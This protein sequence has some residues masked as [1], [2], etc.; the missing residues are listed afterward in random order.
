MGIFFCFQCAGRFRGLGTHIAFVRSV[1][2]DSWTA[3][4]IKAMLLS[5]GNDCFRLFMLERANV[6]LRDTNSSMTFREKYDNNAAELYRRIVQARVREEPEPTELLPT[7]VESSSTGPRRMEGFGSSPSPNADG[8]SFPS[9]D[10]AKWILIPVAAATVT[11]FA[12]CL[13][14]GAS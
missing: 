3:N 9:L 6:D 14:P 10:Q 7:A 4:Q 2:M 11:L 5:G 8:S 12:W 1:T 13:I